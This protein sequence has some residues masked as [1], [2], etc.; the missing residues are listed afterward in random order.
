MMRYLHAH[1]RQL[2][3]QQE[4][5]LMPHLLATQQRMLLMNLQPYHRI[6]ETQ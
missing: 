4:M 1:V 6:I 2:L 3:S 5:L